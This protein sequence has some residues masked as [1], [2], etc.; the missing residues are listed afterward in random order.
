[1]IRAAF[2]DIDGTLVS[3]RTHVISETS[4]N[5]L[6]RLK[7]AGIKVFISSGRP[8]A[9]MDN[10]RDYPF[11]GY[12]SMNG[13][14]VQIGGK[15]I[16]RHPMD[17]E[18]SMMIARILQDNSVPCVTYLENGVCMSRLDDTAIQVMATLAISPLPPVDL[19]KIAEGPVYQY[20]P[21]MTEE[22][23]QRILAPYMKKSVATRWHPAFL[24]IVPEGSSKA[25]GLDEA[26]R[27]LGIRKEETIAFGD[28]GN[29]VSMLE[30]AGIGV[31]MG[32]SSDEVKSHADY[33][34]SSVDEEGVTV[35]L[36]H[37]GLI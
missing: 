16:F 18:E 25:V 26:V 11:D 24:D 37:F 28:G 17:R 31:A 20:T 12:V 32:N 13:S 36:E 35:A 19:T 23:F 4:L 15:T 30:Y 22:L 14:L 1:M 8:V 6:D 7:E 3:F 34:T 10:L 2:F 9:L 33:V 5:S 27:Y 29:D 21:V